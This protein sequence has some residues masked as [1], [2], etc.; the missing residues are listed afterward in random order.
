M[1]LIS[2]D[3]GMNNFAAITNNIGIDPILIKGKKIKAENQWYNKITQPIKTQLVKS[4]NE[5]EKEILNQRLSVIADKTVANILEYFNAT[6]DWIIDYCVR[7]HI[8]V[9]LIGQYKILEKKDFISIPFQNFYMLLETKCKYHNIKYRVINERYTSGTSFFDNEPPTKE[10]YNKDRR[11]YKHLWQCNNGDKVNADVN[12]SYQ[13][14][15]KAHPE[16]FIDGVDGYKR[17]P[18]VVDI[19]IKEGDEKYVQ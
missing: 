1:R 19:K 16:F 2:I 4:K 15:R 13:I 18:I 17:D 12:D 3:I 7:N 5:K 8:D 11:I 14:M 10:F 9:L 6:S